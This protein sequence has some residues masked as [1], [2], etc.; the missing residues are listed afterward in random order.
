[1]LVVNRFRVSDADTTPW[2]ASARDVV[3]FL[4]TRAGVE[5]VEVVRNLDE[6]SLWAIVS[7]WR[8]VGSYRRALQGMEAKM[9]VVP[10][11]SQAIDEPSAYGEPDEVGTNIPRAT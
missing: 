11:L 7:R 5:S 6:S 1:M 2:V 9:L 4:R 8:D 10:L 3:D